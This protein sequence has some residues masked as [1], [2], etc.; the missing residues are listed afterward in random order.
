MSLLVCWLRLLLRVVVE[1][2]LQSRTIARG[3][4]PLQPAVAELQTRSFKPVQVPVQLESNSAAAGTALVSLRLMSSQAG[5]PGMHEAIRRMRAL[6]Q[7]HSHSAPEAHNST[8]AK[9]SRA[10]SDTRVHD[11]RG[12]HWLMEGY[13]K[14]VDGI[15]PL[16]VRRASS[17]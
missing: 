5:K 9:L 8:M 10:R 16:A 4:V 13:A 6:A 17:V 3:I 2:G 14:V 1:E 15:R 11:W 7:L 12:G